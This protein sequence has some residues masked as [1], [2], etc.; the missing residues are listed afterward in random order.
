MS[1]VHWVWRCRHGP[2]AREFDRPGCPPPWP[3]VPAF[4]QRVDVFLLHPSGDLDRSVKT[5][6]QSSLQTVCDL[7]TA[8]NRITTAS[9]SLSLALAMAFCSA[10]TV[11]RKS[12]V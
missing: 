6:S 10:C 5:G 12:V 3:P 9:K 7:S 1:A 2:I 11:D 4:G 8:G